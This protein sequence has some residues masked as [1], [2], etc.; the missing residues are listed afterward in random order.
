MAFLRPA[1]ADYLRQ[2]F[3]TELHDDV[4]IMLFTQPPMQLYI[5]GID[6]PVNL[7][8]TQQLMEEVAAL[9]PKVHLE[10]HNWKEEPALA[11]A[12]GI[13]R[14]PAI[15][16]ERPPAPGA[17]DAQGRA[18]FFGL[19]AGYEFRV[20]VDDLIDLSRGQTE[21]AETTRQRLAELAG[22]LRLQVFVTPT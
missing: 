17:A 9:S 19:P 1:D 22:P 11:Q 4:R 7:R 8:E 13:D 2:R 6:Q 14:V 18:R 5:P 15:V 12:Y 3:A 21:L 16:L 20:L 10:V